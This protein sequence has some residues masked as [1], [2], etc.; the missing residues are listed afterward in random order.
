MSAKFGSFI[1]IVTLTIR[2][3]EKQKSQVVIG[4][5]TI[6]YETAEDSEF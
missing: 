2:M 3:K 1:T 4:K 5:L 6:T